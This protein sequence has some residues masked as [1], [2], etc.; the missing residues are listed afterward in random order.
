MEP[1]RQLHR[2]QWFRVFSGWSMHMP[3]GENLKNCYKELMSSVILRSFFFLSITKQLVKSS[4]VIVGIFSGLFLSFY[5]VF[6][7]VVPTEHWGLRT[8]LSSQPGLLSIVDQ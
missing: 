7:L 1:M 4:S 2:P 5:S 6:V 8:P 3:K